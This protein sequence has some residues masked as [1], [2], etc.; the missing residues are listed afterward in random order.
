MLNKLGP[1]GELQPENPDELPTVPN[2][3]GV[4]AV[5]KTAY[6]QMTAQRDHASE[7]TLLNGEVFPE[8]AR[9]K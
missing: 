3:P 5:P 4:F 9:Q 2:L 8:Q 6:H 7:R 1:R